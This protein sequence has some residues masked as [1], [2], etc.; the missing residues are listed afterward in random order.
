MPQKENEKT[1]YYQ[2]L[3][4]GVIHLD[5]NR[6]LKV[7]HIKAT[8]GITGRQLVRL[9]GLTEDHLPGKSMLKTV[10]LTTEILRDSE[11]IA[12]DGAIF[13]S[14]PVDFIDYCTQT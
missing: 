11:M 8:Y 1:K 3:L 14:I 5:T 2:F 10:P 13:A 7:S 9:G 12:V 6:M 4:D